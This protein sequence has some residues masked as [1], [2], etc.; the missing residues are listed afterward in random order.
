MLDPIPSQRSCLDVEK[1]SYKKAT[2]DLCICEQEE[3]YTT[4][5]DKQN[6]SNTVENYLNNL[7]PKN[8]TDVCLTFR[9]KVVQLA[10]YKYNRSNITDLSDQPD[11]RLQGV[12]E[13]S[14]FRESKVS[15]TVTI[16][17]WRNKGVYSVASVMRDD[18]YSRF[19]KCHSK[20]TWVP[21]I[22]CVCET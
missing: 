17:N 3:F 19:E 22:Y 12:V 5:S 4:K 14:N 11:F 9:L 1:L 18:Y 16:K 20:V 8:A 13:M 7:I 10:R 2:S 6:V 15:F 21:L